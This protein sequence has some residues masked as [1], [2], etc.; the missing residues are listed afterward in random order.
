M[1][2]EKNITQE[3]IELQS[4]ALPNGAVLHNGEREYTVKQFLGAGGFGI[5]YLVS[6]RIKVNNV[7]VNVPVDFAIKEFLMKG[8]EREA[9]KTTVRY[10]ETLR[11]DAEICKQDFITEARRL[12][13]LSGKSRH[14][15]PVNEVFEENNTAY[16]VMQYLK[17]GELSDYILKHKRLSEEQALAIIRPIAEAV[18]CIHKEKLLHLDIKPDNIVF[19]NSPEEYPQHPVLIDFGIA[20]HFDRAGRPT[21]TM[22]PGGCSSGYAPKEQYWMIDHF[23]P[24]VDVYALGATLYAMLV[25]KDPKDA[26]VIKEKDILDNLPP[27]ISERTRQTIINAMRENERTPSVRAFLESLRGIYPLQA[28]FE[29]SSPES[30]VRYRITGVKEGRQTSPTHFVYNAVIAEDADEEDEEGNK[31]DDDDIKKQRSGFDGST[32]NNQTVRKSPV[33]K[34]IIYELFSKDEFVRMDDGSVRGKSDKAKRNFRKETE[35]TKK[36]KLVGKKTRKGLP[37]ADEFEANGTTYFAYDVQVRPPFIKRLL[38]AVSSTGEGAVNLLSWLFNSVVRGIKA[39][40]NG[41]LTCVRGILKFGRLV[42]V[43]TMAFLRRIIKPL[44]YALAGFAIA[45]ATFFG[46]KALINSCEQTPSQ[47]AQDTPA[48][49]D[50]TKRDP[51]ITAPDSVDTIPDH[52]TPSIE[53]IEDT[54]AQ[55]EVTDTLP[56]SLTNEELYNK[57]KEENDYQ[58]LISL[59]KNGYAKAYYDVASYYYSKKD[60]KNAKKYAQKAVNANVNKKQ[61]Q[62]ILDEIESIENT[63]KPPIEPKETDEQKYQKAKKANDYST[64]IALANKGFAKAYIDVAYYYFKQENY[65]EAKRYAQKA[66]DTKT[67][68]TQANQLTQKIDREQKSNE[69]YRKAETY[70]ADHQ[71]DKAL[72]FAKQSLQL[73]NNNEHTHRLRDIIEI[74]L[75]ANPP[76]YS[77]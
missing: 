42:V 38:N 58:S 62:A 51:T 64:L 13:E 48:E 6:A 24:Q 21:S 61:A 27:N 65:N 9:D 19:M 33:S 67:N 46:G 22:S 75:E 73:N 70:F 18:E 76:E 54:I 60:N 77:E 49:T 52:P 16:Y 66:I 30:Q 71:W 35:K 15:V 57:A 20:K 37:L 69:N 50:S 68:E 34:Y 44:A 11:R 4:V 40:L 32:A 72:Y 7:P 14:I 39:C 12:N 25:G 45:T 31:Q 59:A 36:R 41:I 10:P 47:K 55:P 8:G 17:G 1:T 2:S 23:M 53:E 74:C 28:G 5:T 56:P 29:I 26:L 3:K 63:P 43:K